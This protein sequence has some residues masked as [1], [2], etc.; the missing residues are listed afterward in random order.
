MPAPE[1]DTSSLHLGTGARC[2]RILFFTAVAAGNVLLV[3]LALLEH[4]TSTSTTRFS[5]WSTARDLLALNL[6]LVSAFA[7][8]F[9]LTSLALTALPLIRQVAQGE[10]PLIRLL[11]VNNGRGVYLQYQ[12]MPIEILSLTD[13]QRHQPITDE[14]AVIEITDWPERGGSQVAR[15]QAVSFDIPLRIE[16]VPRQLCLVSGVIPV[17]FSIGRRTAGTMRIPFAITVRQER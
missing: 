17:A 2:A 8:R 1:R 14:E 4:R 13:V 3:I 5:V 12:L 9:H 16:S 7:I 6:A 11:C 10:T 15:D